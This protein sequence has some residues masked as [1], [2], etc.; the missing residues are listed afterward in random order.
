MMRVA[1]C[2]RQQFATFGVGD[3]AG[4]RLNGWGTAHEHVPKCLGA[5]CRVVEGVDCFGDVVGV[6]RHGVHDGHRLLRARTLWTRPRP[7]RGV[8]AVPIR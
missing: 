3:F 6:F 7:D 4:E 1:M 8:A 2:G 5:G